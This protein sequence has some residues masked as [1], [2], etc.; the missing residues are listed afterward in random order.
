MSDSDSI[1]IARPE[2]RAV[3]ATELA[4]IAGV[5]A[6]TVLKIAKE[7][8]GML[9]KDLHNELAGKDESL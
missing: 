7:L 5:E 6:S 1:Q 2:R 8:F 9:E 4:G 3:T